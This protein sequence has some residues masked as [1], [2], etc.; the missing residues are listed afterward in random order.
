MA[1]E[2]RPPFKLHQLAYV[3][4]N[5]GFYISEKLVF[6]M[7]QQSINCVTITTL[8]SINHKSHSLFSNT[9]V[10]LSLSSNVEKRNQRGEMHPT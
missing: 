6:T 5:T 9:N 4:R 1:V 10:I 3:L 7:S 2:V 8:A